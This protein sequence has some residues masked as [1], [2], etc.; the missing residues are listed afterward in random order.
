MREWTTTE[1]GVL[2]AFASLGVEATAQ[3]L[4]RSEM[5]VKRK[6]QQL[7]ISMK[8][9]G[10]DID[11]Q[12]TPARVVAWIRQSPGASICPMCGKRLALMKTTGM[13][14]VCHLDR[15]IEI[16][17]EQIA[18]QARERR[19]TTLRQAKKRLRICATCGGDFYPSSKDD[20]CEKC[21]RG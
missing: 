1:I 5:S 8:A 7:G 13:C 21:R 12:I 18:V 14:R 3:L 17:E 10:E 2:R 15:L 9:T 4:E 19:L 20:R 16:R 6:A 11:L